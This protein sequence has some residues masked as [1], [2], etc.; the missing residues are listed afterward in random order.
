MLVDAWVLRVACWDQGAALTQEGA[1]L[2][3]LKWSIV[4]DHCCFTSIDWWLIN[5]YFSVLET[6]KSKIKAPVC[7]CSLEGP[8]GSW[9]APSLC[10]LP[11]QKGLGDLCAVSFSRALILFMRAPPSWRS[12]SQRPHLLIPSPLGLG[13]QHMDLGGNTTFRP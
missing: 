13:F 10:V 6:K 12:T 7:S 3:L 2:L 8:V 11:W 5:I 4:K 1:W 9:I